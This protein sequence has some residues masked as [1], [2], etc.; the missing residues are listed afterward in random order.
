MWLIL[1][2]LTSGFSAWLVAWHEA[3]GIFLERTFKRFPMAL[4][5]LEREFRYVAARVVGSLEVIETEEKFLAT[6]SL[7]IPLAAIVATVFLGGV[8]P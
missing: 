8:A 6:L 1:M 7:L 5:G 4:A 2:G 3:L